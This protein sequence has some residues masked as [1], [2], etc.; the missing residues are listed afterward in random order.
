MLL[1]KGDGTFADPAYHP[2]CDGATDTELGD[3]TTTGSDLVQDGKLDVVVA[4]LRVL[5]G[6]R[7]GRMAGDGAGGFG[8]AVVSPGVV[9][10]QVF[11]NDDPIELANVRKGG[12]PPLL[13]Y[14]DGLLQPRHERAG[15]R[16]RA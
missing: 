8:A 14:H 15:R 5:P 10:G 2:T 13:V 9:I 4:C 3:V 1:N 16:S 7:P 12:G 6:R 11:F